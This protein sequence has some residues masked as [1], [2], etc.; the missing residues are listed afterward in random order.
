MTDH[1]PSREARGTYKGPLPLLKG[2]K[3]S[4][5]IFSTGRCLA[6]FDDLGTGYGLGTHDFLADHFEIEEN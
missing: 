5:V 2:H 4:L 1:P 3:A 6:S